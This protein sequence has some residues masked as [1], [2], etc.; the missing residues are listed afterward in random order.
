MRSSGSP[1]ELERRRRLAVKK[2]DEGH[3][4]ADV[5]EML[6]VTVRSV[7]RWVAAAK[8]GGE[9]ALVAKPASGRPRKLTKK[10]EQ[11]VLRWVR[12][13]PTKFGF[14]TEMW[15]A[16]RL[17]KVIRKRY[18]VTFNANYLIAWLRERGVTAQMPRKVARERDDDA[19]DLWIKNRWQQLKKSPQARSHR[20]FDR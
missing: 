4:P 18:R 10:Q 15:T 3:S 2:V 19:V 16:K 8:G 6:D 14:Q 7:Q 13:S 11:A 1:V 9:R 5:A 20:C 17:A 12:K